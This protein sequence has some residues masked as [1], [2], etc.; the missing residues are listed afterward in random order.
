VKE[1]IVFTKRQKIKNKKHW[2][3]KQWVHM[4]KTRDDSLVSLSW[5]KVYFPFSSLLESSPKMSTHSSSNNIKIFFLCSMRE[6]THNNQKCIMQI[7]CQELFFICASST[8]TLIR[9]LEK[10][11]PWWDGTSCATHKSVTHHIL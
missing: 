3:E 4:P 1:N 2:K 8:T 11:M 5:K 9:E 6:R 7:M 10:I